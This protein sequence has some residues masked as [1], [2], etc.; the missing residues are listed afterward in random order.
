MSRIKAEKIVKKYAEKLRKEGYSFYAIYLFGSYALNKANQW[1]DI[2]VAVI[3]DKLKRN[4]DKNRFLLWDI[5]LDVDNRIEPHA[6]TVEDF[7]NQCDPI[8][9]EIKKTGIR[10]V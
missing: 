6:F 4:T 7:Q 10:I 2:D 8:V 3:S 5:R 1:S 9:Y